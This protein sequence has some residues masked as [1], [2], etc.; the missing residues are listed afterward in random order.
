MR[1]A[2]QNLKDR[3]GGMTTNQRLVLGM[4]AVALLI[5]ASVFGLWLGREEQAVLFADLTAEDASKALAELTKTE[6]S[7]QARVHVEKWLVANGFGAP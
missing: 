2:W 6:A 1:Q 5:S 7:R 4:V 3:L